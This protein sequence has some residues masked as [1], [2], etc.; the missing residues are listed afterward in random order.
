[1]PTAPNYTFGIG[2]NTITATGVG[3]C[4]QAINV[5][6]AAINYTTSPASISIANNQLNN[7]RNGILSNNIK[8]GLRISNNTVNLQYVAISGSRVGIRCAGTENA[9]IDNNTVNGGGTANVNLLGIYMQLSPNCKTQCNTITNTG[10]C[11]V[12]WGNNASNTVGF[13]NNS[14]SNSAVG[15]KLS[16]NGVIGTQG[17]S[18]GIFFRRNSGNTWT[19]TFTFK[20]FTFN[21]TAQTSKLFVQNS[22]A[23]LPGPA[24]TN[25]TVGGSNAI[26]RYGVSPTVIPPTLITQTAFIPITCPTPLM[27]A[28]R[29]APIQPLNDLAQL[30]AQD[31]ALVSLL[32]N[33][34]TITS[35]AQYLQKEFVFA[36]L[37]RPQITTTNMSLQNF[38]L[39]NINT[40]LGH[41]LA[42][43]S[44]IKN[45]QYALAQTKNST[46]VI[47]TNIEQNKNDIN[48][49]L[50]NKLLNDTYAYTASEVQLVETIANKCPLTDGNGVYQARTLLQIIK[51]QYIEFTDSCGADKPS[52]ARLGKEADNESDDVEVLPNNFLLFPNPNN[53]EFNV[54][55]NLNDKQSAIKVSL[56]DVAGKLVYQKELDITTN[57]ASLNTTHLNNGIYHCIITDANGIQLYTNKLVIIK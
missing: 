30:A 42:V 29:L 17:Q 15:L 19:G 18:G 14:M 22:G 23:T 10:N 16:N 27:Q 3:F 48:T 33:T 46:A 25:T 43:D 2:Q 21:S 26:D 39:A 36:L 13:V 31:S 6:L 50:L 51:N 49:Q 7:V 9:W 11:V 41:Y 52:V 5:Q 24:N 53:G 38:A 32:T 8:S 45:G 56:V 34:T 28:A 57:F 54:L 20:T 37:K 55:Y 12:Y 40:G 44:L 47:T 1:M 35:A 4:L